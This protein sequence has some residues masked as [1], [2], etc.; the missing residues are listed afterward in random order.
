MYRKEISNYTVYG[1]TQI[2]IPYVSKLEVFDKDNLPMEVDGKFPFSEE[3]KNDIQMVSGS[4]EIAK[5]LDDLINRN[6]TDLSLLSFSLLFA[7]PH[8][9]IGPG[10]AYTGVQTI[11]Q[12]GFK[13]LVKDNDQEYVS[14][15]AIPAADMDVSLIGESENMLV[16]I[17]A[18]HPCGIEDIYLT[19]LDHSLRDQQILNLELQE[20]VMNLVYTN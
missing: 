7:N 19:I 16:N 3:M 2:L 11:E 12:F 17:K 18:I 8:D 10:I 14:E 20:G 6:G 15:I 13:Y 4:T 9:T 1:M 5:H